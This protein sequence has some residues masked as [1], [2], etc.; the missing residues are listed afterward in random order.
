M[1]IYKNVNALPLGKASDN[2][3]PGCIVLEGGAFRG[4]YT[5]GVLDRLMQSDINME[6]TIGVSAGA[7]NGFNY[8]SGQI[9]RSGRINLTYRHDS[10]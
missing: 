9:G 7:M 3:T 10:R 2:V 8:L 1:R 6:C 5:S 4:V